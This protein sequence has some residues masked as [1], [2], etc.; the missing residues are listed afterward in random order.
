M[1][2][3]NFQAQFVPMIEDGSKKQTIRRRRKYPTRAGQMLQLYMGQ[4]TKHCKMIVQREC[5][6]VLPVK[7]NPDLRL[8][9]VQGE[10]LPFDE[11]Q[12]FAKADGFKSVY[13]FLD[14]FRRYPPEVLENELEVIYWR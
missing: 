3:Y 11:M 6:K 5:V 2:A 13:D 12:E 8:L 7:I 1:P 10:R 14:F 4:R 9:E